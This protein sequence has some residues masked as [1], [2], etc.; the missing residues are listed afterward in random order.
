MKNEVQTE[1]AKEKNTQNPAQI[2]PYGVE[3]G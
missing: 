2:G 1:A 3:I